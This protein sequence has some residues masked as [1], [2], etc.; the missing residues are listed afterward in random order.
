[1]VWYTKKFLQTL[2]VVQLTFLLNKKFD[3]VISTIDIFSS[4]VFWRFGHFEENFLHKLTANGTLETKNI[5]YDCFVLYRD[6]SA[7]NN[8]YT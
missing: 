3:N 4:L 6:S 2:F 5:L 8:Q 7:F 1:M